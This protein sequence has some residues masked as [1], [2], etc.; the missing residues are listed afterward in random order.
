M[1][2]KRQWNQQTWKE[3]EKDKEKKKDKEQKIKFKSARNRAG[4]I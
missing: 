3:K 1:A 4:D 2:A